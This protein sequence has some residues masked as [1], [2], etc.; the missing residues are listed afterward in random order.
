MQNVLVLLKEYELWRRFY[1]LFSV[2]KKVLSCKFL[3]PRANQSQVTSIKML[4]LKTLRNDMKPVASKRV[5]SFSDVCMTRRL[6][7][8]NA[9]WPRRKKLLYYQTLFF[10]RVSPVLSVWNTTY[11]EKDAL[12]SAMYQY[13]MFVPIEEYEKCFLMWNDC[14]Q[15]CL[16][17]K[18]K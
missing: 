12:G 9:M 1:L 18:G 3:C 16:Q 8:M 14:L 2:T 11:L 6:R 5:L 17:P 4:L 15:M 10:S 7:T 13:I